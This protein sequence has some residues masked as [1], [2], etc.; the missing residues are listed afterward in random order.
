MAAKPKK[1][2]GRVVADVASL[3]KGAATGTAEAGSGAQERLS[4]VEAIGD[5]NLTESY[6][7]QLKRLLAMEI[8]HDATIQSLERQAMV[9]STAALNTIVT[10]GANAVNKLVSAGTEEAVGKMASST[11]AVHK[12][13]GTMLHEVDKITTMG[14][15]LEAVVTAILAKLGIQ[16]PQTSD[17]D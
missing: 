12:A 3:T 15:E 4:Q 7:L 8:T 11:Q 5:I 17:E 1:P 6:A 14:N 13:S 2:K 10:A 16:L 9:A